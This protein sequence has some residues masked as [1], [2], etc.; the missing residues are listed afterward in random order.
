MSFSWIHEDAPQW[1]DS[2]NAIIGSAPE[3]SIHGLANY[4]AG[5]VIPGDWWRV[6]EDG[7]VVGY[8]WMDA[9][10]GDAEILLVV[11]PARQKRGAG[12]FILENLEREA[13]RHGLNYMY[14]V[15]SPDHPDRK[16]I[17][18]WLVSRGFERSHDDES[19][20]RRVRAQA[21]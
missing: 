7:A 12:G 20:R 16:G 9:T 18:K 6:E 13:A 4:R 14:N 2:K 19:L 3:G 17:T 1:D 15:V 11:D 10:W 21:T 8:G 5:G